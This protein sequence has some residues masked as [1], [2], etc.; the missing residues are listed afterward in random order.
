MEYFLQRIARLFKEEYGNTLNRHC[1]VFPG[2][3]AGLYLIK[4]LSSYIEKPV[5]LPSI[6]TINDLFRTYSHLQPA[7]NEILLFELY[8]SYSGLTKTPGSFDDFYFWGDM[9]LNDFDDV[10]KYLVNASKIFINVKDLKEIDQRFG[11]LTDGQKNIIRQFWT[12]VD[13]TKPTDEK[14][15]FVNLWAVL[16]DLYEHFGASLRRKNLSYEGMIFRDVAES[17]P[18]ELVSSTQWDIVHFIGFNALNECEK[19]LMKVLQSSGKARFYWDYDESYVNEKGYNSAGFFMKEN[20]KMFGNDMPADWN[21]KWLYKTGASVRRQVVETSSDTAQVKIVNEL[22]GAIPGLTAENAHHT[23]VVLADENLL[24]PLLTSLPASDLNINITMGYPIRHTIVYTLISYLTTLQRTAIKGSGALCFSADCVRGIIGHPLIKELLTDEDAVTANL[25]K[26]TNSAWLPATGLTGGNL[27]SMIF[28]NCESP[29][30]F[31]AWLRII[32]STLALHSGTGISDDEKAAQNI[33]NEF[34][35]RVTLSLNRLDTVISAQDINFS[36]STYIRILERLLRSQSVP[37]S[38]EPLLGIQ[39]MGILE[40]RALDF[41]NLI[42]LSMNEGIVPAISSTSSFIPFSLRQAF[43]MP[44]VNHQESIFSY[45]F[46]RLIQR[47]E[48]VTFVYN[49]DSEGLRS[50]EMS[51]F[52]TQMNFD[53]I[54]KPDYKNLSFEIRSPAMSP[55]TVRRTTDHARMLESSYYPSGSGKILSPSAINSWLSCRMKFFYRYVRGIKEPG[56]LSHEIDAAMFGSILHEIMRFL[57]SGY[58]NR[59]MSQELINRMASDDEMLQKVISDTIIREFNNVEERYITGNELIVREV[60][61]A[62]LKRILRADAA[63]APVTILHL[64]ETFDFTVTFRH[65]EKERAIR[66]GGI[67]DRIDSSV[68]QTRI[69]DYKTGDIASSVCSVDDL[70]EEG[71]KKDFDGW[72]QTLLYCEAYIQKFRNKPVQPSIYGI[73]KMSAGKFETRLLLKPERSGM[74]VDDYMQVRDQFLSGLKETIAKIFDPAEDFKMTETRSNCR[75][76]SY[77]ILCMR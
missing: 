28:K 40:T 77:R 70:F 51:R 14:I 10:D 33:R 9:L 7:G 59:A 31:A 42:F 68:G 39:I 35:Y 63:F 16:N 27:F 25:I 41:R 46:Y 44:S 55:E 57:Y 19:T 45:H 6:L 8:K 74:P 50:G 60:L 32:L 72:L 66:T 23:A 5:W 17:D 71:R 18:D 36:T 12:N 11:G 58:I 73:K 37:F 2:R 43:G 26:S 75:F 24:M 3:R 61:L 20:L 54:L 15:E 76:C 34:I 1:L 49:S 29:S 22:V 56:S 4:Y 69:V 38:G 52:L 13:I 65:E 67:I 30:E 48:N 47:A 21:Y 62:Y 53:T 64:E